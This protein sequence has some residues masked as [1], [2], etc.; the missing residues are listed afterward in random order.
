VNALRAT[1]RWRAVVNAAEAG[2]GYLEISWR[3][4]GAA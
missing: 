1:A 2:G 4:D 3:K